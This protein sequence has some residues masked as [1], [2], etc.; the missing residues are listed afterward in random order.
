MEKTR[1]CIGSS[2]IPDCDYADMETKDVNPYPFTISF[3]GKSVT[4]TEH[5]VHN[6]YCNHPS[7]NK[8]IFI[9]QIKPYS[10]CFCTNCPMT[11][12][13]NSK[14]INIFSRLTNLFIN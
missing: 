8:K 10:S 4:I 3:A 11:N 9:D 13:A 5:I 1:Y 14:L 2:S 12:H 6:V 7:N